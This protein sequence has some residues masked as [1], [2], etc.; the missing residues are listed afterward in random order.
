MYT[1]SFHN[2][3]MYC[4]YDTQF[5]TMS[6]DSVRVTL[7]NTKLVLHVDLQLGSHEFRIIVFLY[8]FFFLEHVWCIVYFHVRPQEEH[9]ELLLSSLL[10][11]TY[12]QNIPRLKLLSA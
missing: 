6:A 10:L 8:D 11:F 5:Y 12:R 4:I 9:M 2:E 1:L 7:G 3:E